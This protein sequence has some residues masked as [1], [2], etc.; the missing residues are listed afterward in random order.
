MFDALGE[1]LIGV[2]RVYGR[3]HCLEVNR[4]LPSLDSALP[5]PISS[6]TVRFGDV[7]HQDG[8]ARLL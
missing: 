1:L 7:F 8:R 5:V 6:I 4:A 3:E 2:R